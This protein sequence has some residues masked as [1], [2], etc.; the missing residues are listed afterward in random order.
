[1]KNKKFPITH[2]TIS[3]KIGRPINSI[4]RIS[5]LKDF[6]IQP[7]LCLETFAIFFDD[8][9]WEKSDLDISV[10]TKN[11]L[12]TFGVTLKGL[13]FFMAME[14]A[15]EFPVSYFLK[16]EFLSKPIHHIF[17]SVFSQFYKFIKNELPTDSAKVEV[18]FLRTKISNGITKVFKNEHINFE[19][20]LIILHRENILGGESQI[21]ELKDDDSIE[22]I[23]QQKLEAGDFVFLKNKSGNLK[24]ISHQLTPIKLEDE[25]KE[26][27][28]IDLL[29]FEII[30]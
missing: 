14:N 4:V 1:M 19:G 10:Q 15:N 7:K 13:R 17:G 18:R 28:W 16:R 11:T 22:V 2:V 6:Y 26:S 30:E 24:N 3:N 5:N 23:F 21:I 29:S 8:L 12:V 20:S 9:P 25:S 27:G